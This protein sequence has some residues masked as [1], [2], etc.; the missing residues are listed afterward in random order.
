MPF[1]APESVRRPRISRSLAEGPLASDAIAILEALSQRMLLADPGG[2]RDASLARGAAG[3]A[4]GHAYMD[5][6]FPH[7]GHAERAR[8]A[9][10]CADAAERRRG[11]SPWLFDGVAGVSWVAE[12]LGRDASDRGDPND[13]REAFL[14]ARVRKE[15]RVRVPHGMAKGLTGV[16]VYALERDGRG[17]STEILG[18]VTRHL[19]WAAC[20]VP[21][22]SFWL[23]DPR[24][25]RN[26]RAAEPYVDN[27][28]ANGLPG[29]VALLAALVRR[30][31]RDDV[32]R[33]LL[34]RTCAW[35]LSARL[36]IALDAWFAQTSEQCVPSRSALFTG[37]PCVAWSLMLAARALHDEALA[38]TALEIA[39]HAA[40]RSFGAS[41]VRDPS[42]GYGAA[43]LAHIFHQ[44]HRLT[45]DETL[46]KAA[47]SWLARTIAMCNAPPAPRSKP[48][49]REDASIADGASGIALALASAVDPSAL[50]WD[51]AFT[52]DGYIL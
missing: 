8:A 2:M 36:P 43:G 42:L 29:V 47:R 7:R 46:A 38:Q 15:L 52:L 3:L 24:W 45:D 22:G 14:L 27:S 32:M 35:V 37:D 21:E 6:L 28:L 49:W 25:D 50:G 41:G 31:F 48:R 19:A 10:A 13:A 51:G 23:S 18:M 33:P 20:N 30:N 9:L 34:T 40:E 17:R 11:A 1:S 5:R 12:H 39:R 44:M 26:S 16:G 4:L